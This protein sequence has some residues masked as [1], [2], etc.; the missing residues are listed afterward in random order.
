MEPVVLAVIIGSLTA[1]KTVMRCA[2]ILVRA[3]ADNMRESARRVT[4]VTMW[5]AMRADAGLVAH[6]TGD[7]TMATEPQRPSAQDRSR[8]TG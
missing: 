8:M 4:I 2:E 6:A 1:I 7:E 5:T 3:H